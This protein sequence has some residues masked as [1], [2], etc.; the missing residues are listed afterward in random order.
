MQENISPETQKSP[1]LT[2][3]LYI[4]TKQQSS[5]MQYYVNIHLNSLKPWTTNIKYNVQVNYIWCSKHVLT[6][7]SIR[8]EYSIVFDYNSFVS[9]LFALHSKHFFELKHFFRKISFWL[10]SFQFSDP[11]LEIL[12][13]S[14]YQNST[15]TLLWTHSVMSS[16]PLNRTLPKKAYRIELNWNGRWITNL[17]F[18]TSFSG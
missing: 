4:Q 5:F 16:E 3:H 10:S 11:I 14:G 8:L 15:L 9:S 12:D 6:D 18:L 17:I 7:E 13:Q 1:S 2:R